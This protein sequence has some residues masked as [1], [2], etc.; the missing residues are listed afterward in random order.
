[1]VSISPVLCVDGDVVIVFSVGGVGMGEVVAVAIAVGAL[2]DAR[3]I[4]YAYSKTC[5][6]IAS[7][8]SRNC[9][10]RGVVVVVVVVEECSEKKQGP[11]GGKQDKER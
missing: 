7:A 6:M 1:M 11:E 4:S 5:E 2:N 8:V 10:G 3:C 9:V